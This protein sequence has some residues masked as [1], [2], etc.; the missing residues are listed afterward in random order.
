MVVPG[1]CCPAT[2]GVSVESE[3]EP[4]RCPD[5]GCAGRQHLNLQRKFPRNHAAPATLPPIV[6]EVLRSP[7][8]PLDLATHAFPR[9]RV[10]GRGFSRTTGFH[11]AFTKC[12][13]MRFHASD[14]ITGARVPPYHAEIVRGIFE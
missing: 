14:G 12:A 10:S 5:E 11:D 3:T 4:T 1:A 7:G 13:G 9:N 2:S 6:H 8:L